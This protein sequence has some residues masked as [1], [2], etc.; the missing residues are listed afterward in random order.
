MFSSL[1]NK[2]LSPNTKSNTTLV[3]KNE[4]SGSEKETTGRVN[5]VVVTFM[6]HQ[7]KTCEKKGLLIKL[8]YDVLVE[9]SSWTGQQRATVVDYLPWMNQ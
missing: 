9:F 3:A 2:Q 7:S 5:S 6:L 1:E 4:L 8:L